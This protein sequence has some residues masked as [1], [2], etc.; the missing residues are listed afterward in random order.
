M[1]S[2][3]QNWANNDRYRLQPSTPAQLCWS[4]SRLQPLQNNDLIKFAII[5]PSTLNHD[6]NLLNCRGVTDETTCLTVFFG[7][8]GALALI[9]IKLFNV[10]AKKLSLSHWNIILA[11]D[12]NFQWLLVA[13]KCWTAK[14]HS[15]YVE[16]SRA[17]NLEKVDSDILPRTLQPWY[18]DYITKQICQ[19]RWATKKGINS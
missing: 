6:R 16:K 13:K 12:H 15:C 7:V 18:Q 11:V 9:C 10:C 14:F 8:L 17:G 2:S 5:R 3:L 4:S 1:L 19:G